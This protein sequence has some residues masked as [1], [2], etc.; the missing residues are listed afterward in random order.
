VSSPQGRQVLT[1]NSGSSS[2]KA[3]VYL[4]NQSELR[5]LRLEASRI[6]SSAGRLHVIGPDGSR[7]FDAA[8]QLPDY[9]AALDALLGWMR[10]CDPPLEPQ[11]VAHRVVHGGDRHWEPA[12]ITEELL[13][14]LDS[15]VPVDSEHMPQAIACIRALKRSHPRQL[16]IACFDTGFHHGMPAVARTY[17]LPRRLAAAGIRRYGFHGLSYE[18]VTQRLGELEGAAATGR[19]VVAHLGNGASLAAIRNG[20]SIDTTMGF[21]PTGGLVMG[22]RC[23]DL[24]PQL[25]LYLLRHEQLTP[26]QVSHLL[27]GESGLLGV[28]ETTHDMR[29]LLEREAADP[30]AAEAV[31]LFCY[32]AAKYLAGCAAA[33]GGLDILVFTAGIGERAAPIRDR[34]CTRL[35]FLGIELDRERN[36]RHEPVI[37]SDTSRIKVRIVKTN[38]ELMIARHA[39]RLAT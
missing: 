1:I 26:D 29:E 21:S 16:Q 32:Q 7:L 12:P 8:H 2:L 28:S 36:Q 14:T 27:S 34:I 18:Y 9:A 17:P 19:V 5:L 31:A 37:S 25:V 39:S 35:A 38:E 20:R 15:L 23:G 4:M 30:R 24:D 22:T 33:L 10:R 6:G 13:A 3:A 11:V